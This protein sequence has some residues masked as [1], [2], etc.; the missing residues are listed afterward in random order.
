MSGHTKFRT[1][2]GEMSL[3]RPLA[4]MT[5]TIRMSEADVAAKLD[6]S[7]STIKL[8]VL[9]RTES[10]RIIQIDVGSK[11]LREPGLPQPPGPAFSRSW[12]RKTASSPLQPQVTTM[13]WACVNTAPTAWLTRAKRPLK[14]SATILPMFRFRG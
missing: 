8:E 3:L 1:A 14:S 5:E 9:S 13:Q 7:A 2:L 11:I 10:G 6:E 12:L 4:R